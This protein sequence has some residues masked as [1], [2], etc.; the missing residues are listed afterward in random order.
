MKSNIVRND[1]PRL[2]VYYW[3]VQRGTAYLYLG[4]SV[5]LIKCSRGVP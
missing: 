4:D 1:E 3:L 2:I 5:G